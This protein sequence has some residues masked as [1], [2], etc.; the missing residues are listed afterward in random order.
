[1]FGLLYSNGLDVKE[2]GAD[3]RGLENIMRAGS[4]LVLKLCLTDSLLKTPNVSNS[5]AA[6]K[7]TIKRLYVQF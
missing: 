6:N 7:T 3:L 5:L 1:M 2:T 4:S